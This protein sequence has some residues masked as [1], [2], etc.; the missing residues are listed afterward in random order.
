MKIVIV[1]KGK[2][3]PQALEEI[4]TEESVEPIWYESPQQAI[5]DIRKELPQAI[6]WNTMDFPQIWQVLMGYL[7]GVK[8]RVHVALITEREF[9]FEEGAESLVLGVSQIIP[10]ALEKEDQKELW[11]LFFEKTPLLS[12]KRRDPSLLPED[13]R[14]P[15]EITEPALK[16]WTERVGKRVTLFHPETDAPIEG[17]VESVIHYGIQFY[18]EQPISCMDIELGTVIEGSIYLDERKTEICFYSKVMDNNLLLTL[19][20]VKSRT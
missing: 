8:K 13:E 20:P 15:I 5:E 7:M 3:L 1:Q 2:V 9:Y 6:C 17:E 14:E 12:G 10:F 18:P 11:Y 4:F 16:R 19:L